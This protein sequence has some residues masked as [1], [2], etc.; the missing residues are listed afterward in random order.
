MSSS[1]SAGVDAYVRDLKSIFEDTKDI[2]YLKDLNGTY[3]YMNPAGSRTMGRDGVGASDLDL[4]GSEVA[5]E[6][7]AI[8]HEIVASLHRHR[9]YV[10][11]RKVGAQER[12]FYTSKSAQKRDGVWV[13]SGVTRDIT[14]QERIMR[15]PF[16]VQATSIAHKI[17]NPLSYAIDGI[18]ALLGLINDLQ[19]LPDE[20]RRQ[21]LAHAETTA[22]G[23]NRIRDVVIDNL[24]PEQRRLPTPQP[25][26]STSARLK[27]LIVDDEHRRGR[28]LKRSLGRHHDVSSVAGG[29]QAIVALKSFQF[30]VVVSDVVMPHVS[31]RELYEWIE[32]NLPDMARRVIFMTGGAV[33]RELN[34]FI[35]KSSRSVLRKPFDPQELLAAIARAGRTLDD[36]G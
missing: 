18:Q 27:V 25:A 23:L 29:A 10:S 4:F 7:L 33:T 24:M 8:D 21:L 5:A 26:P 1:S 34:A 32:A 28:A 11:V 16:D 20:T 6:I 13:I 9:T 30:D 15:H 2:V 12:V 17:N 19:Q 36:A 35:K 3:L 22:H 31:G 14:A